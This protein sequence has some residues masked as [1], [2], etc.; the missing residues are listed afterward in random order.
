M[1]TILLTI[2][3]T[4]TS[5][6]TQAVKKVLDEKAIKYSSNILAGIVSIVLSLSASTGYLIMK[7]IAFNPKVAVMSLS[8]VALNWLCATVGYDKVIQ[9]IKQIKE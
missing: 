7:D 8:F 2:T 6:T 5:L 9:A 1:I 3:A 4:F